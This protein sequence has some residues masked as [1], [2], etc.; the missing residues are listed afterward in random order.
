[1][2]LQNYSGTLASM[3]KVKAGRTVPIKVTHY[4][5]SRCNLHCGFCCVDHIKNEKDLTTGQVQQ[6]MR[7]FRQAGTQ[8]YGFCGGEPLL[9]KDIDELIQYA[10]KLG[11]VIT[12]TTNGSLMDKHLDALCEADFVYVSLDG[13]RKLHDRIRGS[14]TFD[15]VVRNIDLLV[16]KGKTP[17]IN[18]VVF[19][20]NLK[21]MEFLAKL[22][23]SHRCTV[24]YALVVPNR[25]ENASYALSQDQVK[26]AYA[27]MGH[28]K[29]QYPSVVSFSPSYMRRVN[30]LAGKAFCVVS[31]GGEVAPCIDLFGKGVSGTSHGFVE[32]FRQLRNPGCDCTWRCY[33]K[34]SELYS[35]NPVFLTRAVY[36]MAKDRGIHT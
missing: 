21:E 4:I 34:S 28:L 30:C 26:Q 35:L 1:V 18:M 20:G 22:A 24:D 7:E 3:L 32:A 16:A 31:P 13:P 36:R 17:Q 19:P 23:A 27:I 8:V 10:K 6:C 29:K 9:R 12:L 33:Y 25:A 15:T 14:P 5:T 2:K 11:Y